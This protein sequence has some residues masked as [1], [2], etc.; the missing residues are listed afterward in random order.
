[1]ETGNTRE[2]LLMTPES[3]LISLLEL[4]TTWLVDC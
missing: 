3:C 2:E 1:M 4:V